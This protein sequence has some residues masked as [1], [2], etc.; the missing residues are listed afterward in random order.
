MP[1]ASN[2]QY[3]LSLLRIRQGYKHIA[4][5]TAGV[6]VQP[7]GLK[8]RTAA[9]I[10][11][12]CMRRF[13]SNIGLNRIGYGTLTILVLDRE[14]MDGSCIQTALR[15]AQRGRVTGSIGL[16]KARF[17]VFCDL[18]LGWNDKITDRMHCAAILHR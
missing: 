18:L 6:H 7:I 10:R 2:Y 14:V 4:N 17:I 1:R 3:P 11:S 8:H 15:I 5:R 9:C 16:R 13:G 12:R